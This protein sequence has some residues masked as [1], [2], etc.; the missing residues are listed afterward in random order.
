METI[1]LDHLIVR[2]EGESLQLC[3]SHFSSLGLC[4]FKIGPQLA[5][6]FFTKLLRVSECEVFC[7]VNDA[8]NMKY[9]HSLLAAVRL[10]NIRLYLSHSNLIFFFFLKSFLK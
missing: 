9:Y 5:M 3:N 6:I 10:E 4:I 2:E 1:T 7:E 8:N